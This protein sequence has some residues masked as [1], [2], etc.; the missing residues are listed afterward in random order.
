MGGKAVEREIRKE[1]DIYKYIKTR[2]VKYQRL[3]KT[4]E[5][6]IVFGHP[7]ASVPQDKEGIW[8][9]RMGRRG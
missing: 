7:S 2:S 4:M 5:R 8:M 1:E 3:T 6:Q 9:E